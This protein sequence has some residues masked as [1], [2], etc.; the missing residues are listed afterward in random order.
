MSSLHLVFTSPWAGTAL[1]DCLRAASAGDAVLLLQD[2]VYA[3]AGGEKAR[4]LLAQAVRQQLPVH[5]LS[6]DLAARGLQPDAGCPAQPVSD[7]GFVAL[8][9]QHERIVSWF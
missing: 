6:P 4:E 9:E 8:T 1:T 3:A 7:D 5:L 2:G